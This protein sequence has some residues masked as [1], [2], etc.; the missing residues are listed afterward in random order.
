M[1]K[2][3]IVYFAA[4]LM[5]ITGVLGTP[6]ICHGEENSDL[7]AG[8]DERAA[9]QTVGE[10]G[11]EPVYAENLIEGTYEIEVDSSS[12]MFR[13][14]HADLT[15]KDGKMTAVLTLGGT[16]YLKLF[17][18][19]GEEAVAADESAYAAFVEDSEGAYTYE[20]PVEALNKELE[21]TGFS[22]RKEKWYDHQIFFKAE[23]LPEEAFAVEAE[24]IDLKDGEY[25]VQ[26][27]LAGG[28]GRAEITSPAVLRIEDQSATAV[29]EWSSSNYDYMVV[30]GK[31]YF[32]VNSEGNSVFEIPVLA[33]D[34][35]MT[36]T[37]DTTAMST[38]HEIEYMLTF[39]K[40]SIQSGTNA[41]MIA[42]GV[43]LA[44]GA[45]VALSLIFRKKKGTSNEAK[46]NI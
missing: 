12:S 17:M 6:V 8:D 18:G 5:M 7:I 39:D 34:K 3:R 15:V 45:A 36:V 20:V 4:L 40:A 21:C 30:N 42:V 35:A 43:A 25:T 31:K 27:D 22:K 29:I 28:T 16:G 33:F 19:T 44:V 14:V 24:T 11:A 32:P 23:T 10:E 37:A 1:L 46:K 9:Q 41:T 38:P 13:I 2:K 26:V